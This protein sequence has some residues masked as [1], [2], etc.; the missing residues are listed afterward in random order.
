MLH[1]SRCAFQQASDVLRAT[2]SYLSA[3]KSGRNGGGDGS[4]TA[5]LGFGSSVW[6]SGCEGRR[7]L[8]FPPTRERRDMGPPAFERWEGQ[9][10]LGFWVPDPGA[11]VDGGLGFPPTRERRDMGP[12]AFEMR[13]P[14]FRPEGDGPRVVSRNCG[15]R[16]SRGGS[17][18]R[19]PRAAGCRRCRGAPGAFCRRGSV[20]G[21]CAG[22]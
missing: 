6:G 14:C 3:H 17:R 18:L 4:D 16:V 13:L 8:G 7:G 2:A 21:T 11:R 19:R 20:R 5:S 1:E 15:P 9:R 22:P 10:L 12:P